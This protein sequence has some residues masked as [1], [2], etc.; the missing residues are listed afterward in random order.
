VGGFLRV[1]PTGLNLGLQ[2]ILNSPAELAVSVV[3]RREDP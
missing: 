3:V 1:I 2:T